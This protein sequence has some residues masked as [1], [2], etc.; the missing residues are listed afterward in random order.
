M[1]ARIFVDFPRLCC[2]GAE[3]SGDSPAIPSKPL[4][5]EAW[6]AL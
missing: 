1:H 4:A 5:A 3:P 2:I 6:Q